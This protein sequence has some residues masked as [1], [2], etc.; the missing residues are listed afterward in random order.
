[1]A[2]YVARCQSVTAKVSTTML[3]S[4]DS[5]GSAAPQEVVNYVPLI[6]AV[7]ITLHRFIKF[8]MYSFISIYISIMK[9]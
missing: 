5:H 8:L 4:F 9:V 7:A 2:G 1:M 3:V 6:R